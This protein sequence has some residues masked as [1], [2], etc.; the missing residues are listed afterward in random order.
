MKIQIDRCADITAF[1]SKD[2]TRLNLLSVQVEPDS[3]GLTREPWDKARPAAIVATDGHR[4]AVVE[5]GQL[6][7]IAGELELADPVD[8]FGLPAAELRTAIR[9]LPKSKGAPSV[10]ALTSLNGGARAE[11]ASV[12]GAVAGTAVLTIPET[13][14]PDA[15]Q[16]MPSTGPTVAFGVNPQ[17]LADVCAHAKACGSDK[18]E[19]RVIDPLSPIDIHF[20][21]ED[22]RKV[23][24][25]IMPQRL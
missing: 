10:L 1:A 20:T 13:K 15:R 16:V 21:M 5:L 17:Y 2:V 23:R 22:G 12:N 18:I 14:F 4:L 9:G 19:I 7:P 6:N 25:I 8:P 11:F 24:H 3:S